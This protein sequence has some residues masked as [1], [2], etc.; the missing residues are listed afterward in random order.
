MALKQAGPGPRLGA[1][2]MVVLLVAGCANPRPAPVVH[3]TGTP[4]PAAAPPPVATVPQPP[5]ALPGQDPGVAGAPVPGEPPGVI[6]TPIPS[7]SIE[8]AP[9][10][11][12][13][14][15]VDPNLKTGPSGIKRP[16]GEVA[17]VDQRNLSPGGASA[18]AP[19]VVSTTAAPNPPAAQPAPAQPAPPPATVATAPATIKPAP[20]TAS[21]TGSL[22]GVPFAW[23]V[24]G[25]V[26]ETFDQTSNKGLSLAGRA[27]DT[28]RAA[29]D[30]RV[31]FSGAGPRGYGNLVIVKHDKELL[32]VYAHNRSLAVKEGQDVKRGQKIAEL[33]SS[34]TDVPKLHFEIRQQGKPIDPLAVLPRR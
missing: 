8:T 7:G 12:G 18:S 27:G 11:Q 23:P 5:E 10:Q 31:I 2:V 3:R 20:A 14:A 29:A 17:S 15:P 9:L 32:S 26:L 33:G 22:D 16:Y 25:T 21:G 13:T 30:G 6:A 28:V 19:A 1:A 4:Q 34:G 24:A